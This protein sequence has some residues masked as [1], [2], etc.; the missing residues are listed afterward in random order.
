[1]SRSR[2]LRPGIRR[3]ASSPTYPC[4]SSGSARRPPRTEALLPSFHARTEPICWLVKLS[5]DSISTTSGSRVCE[6]PSSRP[7]RPARRGM[8]DLPTAVHSGVRLHLMY[9]SRRT[10]RGRRAPSRTCRAGPSAPSSSQTR[11]FRRHRPTRWSPASVSPEPWSKTSIPL[12][13]RSKACLRL[14]F[15]IRQPQPSGQLWK[16]PPTSSGLAR[17]PAMVFSSGCFSARYFGISQCSA[18]PSDRT[19]E[20]VLHFAFGFQLL[21]DRRGVDPHLGRDIRF[22]VFG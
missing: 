18:P 4:R 7:S 16:R 3:S 15:T 21:V 12:P 11:A 22:A 19:L 20:T 6:M 17:T 14:S 1:M 5:F 10:G 2:Q 9:L 13:A 8:A